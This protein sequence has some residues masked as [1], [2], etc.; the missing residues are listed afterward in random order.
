M[1]NVLNDNLLKIGDAIRSE[2]RPLIAVSMQVQNQLELHAFL[3]DA[4]YT[5]ADV[6]EWRIDAW[7]DLTTLTDS[8]ISQTIQATERPI[9]LTWRTQDEG[10]GKRFDAAEYSR[11]YETAI[12]ADV[13]AVD[14]EVKL[15]DRLVHLVTLAQSNDV[16]VIGS[17]HDW[18]FPNNL[19]TRMH[20]MLNYPIDV[21]KYVA[22]S[23]TEDEANRVLDELKKLTHQTNKPVIAMA[24]GDVGSFTR[25]ENFANGSQLT[26]A[27]LQQSS[28]PGQLDIQAVHNYFNI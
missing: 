17:R 15:L 9:I 10:G 7:S 26:F 4:A 24:M 21:I 8:L 28:A 22:M 18:T 11:I 5:Q 19:S 13:G 20:D 25:L 2:K 3:T 27:Q 12:Q 6:L 14:I 1:G 16:T 23:E